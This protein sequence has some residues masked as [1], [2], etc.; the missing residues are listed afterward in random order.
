LD[1]RYEIFLNH[2]G[3]LLE[4]SDT[5]LQLVQLESGLLEL[6]VLL[7]ELLRLLSDLLLELGVEL[8]FDLGLALAL[9][10]V[11]A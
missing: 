3:L 1:L 10:Q 8:V 2:V 7:L 6:R 5:T 11:E 9:L 4:L